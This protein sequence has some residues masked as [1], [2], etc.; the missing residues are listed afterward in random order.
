MFF[1]DAEE[2]KTLREQIIAEAILPAAR[3]VFAQRP[4][5][6]SALLAVAQ[7]W[8]DEAEDAVHELLVFSTQTLVRTL[9]ECDALWGSRLNKDE[10]T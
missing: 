10:R 2:A 1:H 7:C 8:D 5:I 6:Q 3:A 4:Q 9:Q